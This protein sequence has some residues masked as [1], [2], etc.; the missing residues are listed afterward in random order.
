MCTMHMTR[1]TDCL[2]PFHHQAEDWVV[3][4]CKYAE[5]TSYM[6]SS[7]V[8]IIANNFAGD[9]KDTEHKFDKCTMCTCHTADLADGRTPGQH[10]K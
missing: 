8:T 7:S 3:W 4:K 10:K 2:Q 5:E 6:T 1:F 9:F